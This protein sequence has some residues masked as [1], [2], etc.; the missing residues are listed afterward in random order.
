MSD[1][2]ENYGSIS[3]EP[4]KTTWLPITF[5]GSGWKRFHHT[6]CV[7]KANSPSVERH[8]QII[9]TWNVT[10]QSKGFLPQSQNIGKLSQS[11]RHATLC[12]F[13]FALEDIHSAS[14]H[15]DSTQ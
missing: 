2:Y 1:N 4:I 12:Y 15:P 10:W 7:R 14:T 8:G 9:L 5:I 6:A 3:A 13:R 11:V